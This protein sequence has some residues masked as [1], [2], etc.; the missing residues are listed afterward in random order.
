MDNI[1]HNRRVEYECGCNEWWPLSNLFFCCHCSKTRCHSCAYVEIDQMFCSNCLETVPPGEARLKRNRC[2]NCHQC[3]VC[4]TILF[5]RA[6]GENTFL[7]C[8]TCR[9]TTKDS[10]IP[11]QTTSTNWP[12]RENP[13]EK[14]LNLVE[15]QLRGF[16]LIEKSKR[17]TMKFSKRRSNTASSLTLT[18]RYNLQFSYQKRK[19]TM[20]KPTVEAPIHEA[21]EEVPE[22][23]INEVC[24]NKREILPLE[25]LIRQPLDY[26]Q[27]LR[28]VR[29]LLTPR[30]AIRCKECDHNVIKLDHGPCAFKYKVQY[31]AR[32]YI[33]EVKL[34]R[35]PELLRDQSTIVFLSIANQSMDKIDVKLEHQSDSKEQAKFKMEPIE[36]SLPPADEAADLCET[37]LPTTRID[38]NTDPVVFRRR[39]RVGVRLE[40][41]C[42]NSTVLGI[43]LSYRSELLSMQTEKSPPE[44]LFSNIRVHL[45]N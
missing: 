25:T 20:E 37:P 42:S 32:N 19:K 38:T 14:E 22:L 26:E 10:D 28:P 30:K 5:V 2:H 40:A 24:S 15:D 44:W 6:V 18:D 33:P 41:D 16:A 21:S 31:F 23:D 39:H 8:G 1:S 34:S 13:L 9:W 4:E 29:M 43:R 17:D 3:P 11:F 12:M 27:P 45:T 7:T 36:L 35:E